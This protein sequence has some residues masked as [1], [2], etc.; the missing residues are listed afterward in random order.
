MGIGNRL[1]VAEGEGVGGGMEWEVGLAGVSC[2][3]ENG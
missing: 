1:V 3:T 2:Y